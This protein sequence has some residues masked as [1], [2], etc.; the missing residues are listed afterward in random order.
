LILFGSPRSG[1]QEIL[2]EEGTSLE[3]VANITLNFVPE[4]GTATVRTE[5]ALYIVLGI[6][7]LLLHLPK[8]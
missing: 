8:E 3:N 7:N 5:E 2:Q 6:I 1:L 4:Q